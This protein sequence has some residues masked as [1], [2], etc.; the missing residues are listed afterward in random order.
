MFVLLKITTTDEDDDDVINDA[1]DGGN[2]NITEYSSSNTYSPRRIQID[3]IDIIL[4]TL[5]TQEYK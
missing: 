5:Y 1:D 3:T 4:I 2:I